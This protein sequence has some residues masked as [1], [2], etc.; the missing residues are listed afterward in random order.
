M[1]FVKLAQEEIQPGLGTGAVGAGRGQ[2]TVGDDL[3][4][5]PCL[6]A[7]RPESGS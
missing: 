1:S 2:T 7:S 3:E 4:H 6:P 5:T